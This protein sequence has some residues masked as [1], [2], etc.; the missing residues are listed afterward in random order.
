MDHYIFELIEH[1]TQY[2][3]KV[4]IASIDTSSFHWHYDYELMVVLKGS[5]VMKSVSE[6][7]IL[8]AG[9]VV[10][11]NSKKVHSL[12]R[13]DQ[14]NLC[15]FIQL[16][17]QLFID[18]SNKKQS[19]SFYLNSA[20]KTTIPKV[21]F[22]VFLQTAVKIA[23][24]SKSKEVAD[25][26]RIKALIATL[27]ADL[28]EYTQYDIR[29]YPDNIDTEHNSDVLLQINEFIERNIESA[30]ITQELC[31][32]IGMSEKTLYRFL[33]N[34][35]GF[36]AKDLIDFTRIEKSK[37]MLRQTNKSIS[38]IEQECGFNSEVTF[39]RIFKKETGVTPNEYRENDLEVATNSKVQGYLN[40]DNNEAN[41]L[42]KQYL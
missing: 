12:R 30:N 15:L 16:P 40:F 23:I 11:F 7:Y 17:Q 25:V 32:Y 33:K 20:S 22:S 38:F 1:E 35:T 31:K 24:R 5:L 19:Y 10:L 6:P 42:L 28:I 2:P 3:A 39:Y 36:T 41:F 14:D 9:D 26:F 37:V 13:T 27:V 18:N 21:K 29:Q 8:K 4:F 34:S